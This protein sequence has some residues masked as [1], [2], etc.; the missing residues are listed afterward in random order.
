ML[1]GIL[2]PDIGDINVFGFDYKTELSEIRQKIGVCL[3]ID[4]LY[5]QLTVKEHLEFYGKLKGFYY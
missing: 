1:T 3:Q 4:V 2:K 5:D